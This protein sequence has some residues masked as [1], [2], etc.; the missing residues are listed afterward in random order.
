M[1]PN[2]SIQTERRSFFR[3]RPKR[4]ASLETKAIRAVSILE[5]ALFAL[6][7]TNLIAEPGLLAILKLITISLLAG[8]VTLHHQPHGD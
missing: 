7:F 8:I 4:K 6:A 5:I 2:D 1:N 3:Y